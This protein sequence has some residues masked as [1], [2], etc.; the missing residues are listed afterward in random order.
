M[1]RSNAR[2]NSS[3]SVVSGTCDGAADSTSGTSGTTGTSGAAA[4]VVSAV[5]AFFRA[6]VAGSST[7]VS[8]VCCLGFTASGTKSALTF[9]KS[10]GMPTV[11]NDAAAAGLARVARV[12]VATALR[13]LG[14]MFRRDGTRNPRGRRES[15][16]TS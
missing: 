8:L 2:S 4:S 3:S 16:S 10:S 9:L 13:L 6:A 12:V 1:L 5:R 14:A 7:T 11:S 15:E